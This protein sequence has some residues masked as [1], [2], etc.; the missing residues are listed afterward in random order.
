MTKFNPRILLIPGGGGSGPDHWQTF[1]ARENA[2]MDTV[3][4]SD[5]NGGSR[6]VWVDTLN[7]HIQASSQPTILVAHSLGCIVV[8]H[9]AQQFSGPIVGALLVAPADVEDE[10]AKDGALYQNF[11]PIPTSPLP[12]PSILVSST[13]DPYLTTTRASALAAAWGSDVHSV[14]PLGHI[15]SDRKL[16]QWEQGLLILHRLKAKAH[17][18]F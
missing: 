8:H 3:V 6:Q 12:F 2:H 4:Q 1:W 18:P 16:E 10:W 9:W 14:G 13:N 15:G 5:W 11:K 17:E 7:L